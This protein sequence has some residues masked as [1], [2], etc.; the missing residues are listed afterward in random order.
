MRKNKEVIYKLD[1]LKS[2]QEIIEDLANIF[3]EHLDMDV[4]EHE[5]KERGELTL[6]Y[7]DE[8]TNNF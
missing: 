3:I 4:V 5:I 7:K 1:R 6:K 2:D 8:S